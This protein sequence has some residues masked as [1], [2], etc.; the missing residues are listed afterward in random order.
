MKPSP[1]TLWRL[2]TQIVKMH[3]DQRERMLKNHAMCGFIIVSIEEA[4]AII[5]HCEALRDQYANEIL[6]SLDL[7]TKYA[8]S[9]FFHKPEV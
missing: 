4:D 1:W 9:D 2:Y 7:K 8:V 6:E 3:K 5:K